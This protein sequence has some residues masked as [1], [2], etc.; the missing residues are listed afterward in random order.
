M[1][2]NNNAPKD[3]EEYLSELD[4]LATDCAGWSGAELD[5]NRAGAVRDLVG[6]I[7]KVAKSAEKDRKAIKE[8]YLEQG[9]KVDAA[10][11]PVA[12][13]ATK[14]MA[15]LKAMLSKWLQAEEERKRAEAEAA[16]KEAE[17]KAK[18][19]EAL[20]DDDTFGERVVDMAKEAKQAADQAA[21]LA[22]HN[23]VKGNDS[24]RALGLR[25]YRKAK[26]V[27]G[28]MLVGHFANHPDVIALCEKIAN[29]EIR[30]SGGAPVSIP[31]IEVIEE[32]RVA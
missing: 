19:A 12:E 25:T 30:A 2:V 17:E 16:R 1:P 26:I 31:G 5:E 4:G 24:D 23:A 14:L 6:K 7:D 11:K 8:P 10:F 27:N 32:K 15:P 22:D 20:K 29:A 21:R 3:A 28:A 13:R 18:L 9:R